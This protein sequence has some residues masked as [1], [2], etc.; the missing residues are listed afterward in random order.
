MRMKG[1]MKLLVGLLLLCLATGLYAS[2]KQEAAPAEEN[3]VIKIWTKFNDTNPQNSQ[4]EW[5]KRTIE[6][7][8]A[9]SGYTVNNTFVPYDQIN[10]KLNLA[11]QAGGEV[12]DLSYCDGDIEFFTRN[13]VLIDITDYMT[14]ADWYPSLMDV[15]KAGVV[16]SDGRMYAVPAQLGGSMLYYWTAAYPDG[17]PKTT[18]DLLAAGARLKADDRFA[19]TFKGSEGTGTSMFYFQLVETFGGTYTDEAGRSVFATEETAQAIEF[20]RELFAEGYV[21]EVTLGAGFDFET[22]FKDGSAG[23][24]VAGSWSYVYLNPLTSPDGKVFDNGPLSVED[25]LKSGAMGIA[26]P[27]SVPGGR[28]Y[29]YVSG[30]GG[31]GIPTGS[32]NVKG[33]QMLLDYLMRAENAAD[34]AFSYGGLPTIEESMAD[35]RFAE[36]TYWTEVG[37]SINRTGKQVTINKNPKFFQKF[38]ETVIKLIQRPNLDIMTELKKLQDELNSEL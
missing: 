12:P 25:A 17:P 36:S 1:A 4:D 19:I 38:D 11:V 26:D 29:T 9:E 31:F 33:A 35:Q 30:F 14:A 32:K 16:A 2:G 5:L 7:F 6:A 18:E 20:L 3:K 21:P 23:A 22:P 15:A 10:S 37:A 27:I 24:F 28:P 34:Y 8:E 13:E